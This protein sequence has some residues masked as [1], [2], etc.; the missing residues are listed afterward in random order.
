[1]TAERGGVHTENRTAP[2]SQFLA[3]RF[4]ARSPFWSRLI[5][6][7]I[8]GLLAFVFARM[9]MAP[10]AVTLLG[11][12]FGVSGAVLLGLAANGQDVVVA[13][14]LLLLAYSLDCADGQLARATGRTSS[15]GAWL[16]VTVDAVVTSF[17]AVA[18]L[19]ALLSNG[20]PL[21]PSLLTAGAFGA[22]RMAVLFTASRVSSDNGGMQVQGI[23][24]LLRATFLATIDTPFIY[25]LLTVAR[26]WTVVLPAVLLGI[27]ALS[28]VQATVSAHAHFRSMA[29]RAPAIAAE[30]RQRD[31]R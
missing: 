2:L 4:A 12:A 28:T 21:L 1:M 9:R 13:G 23:S 7:R 17:L 22:A 18:V 11:G 10:N 16:D 27:A 30:L 3:L 5:F 20:T 14:A 26:F 29:A 6:E 31:P 8:G 25:V 19:A 15:A 24:A